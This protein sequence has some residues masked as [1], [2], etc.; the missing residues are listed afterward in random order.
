MSVGVFVLDMCAH[1]YLFSRYSVRVC[2]FVCLCTSN[3]SLSYIACVSMCFRNCTTEFL[4]WNLFFEII[5]HVPLHMY[6]GVQLINACY[7]NSLCVG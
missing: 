3:S 4:F 6:I 1:C 5:F 2:A 7:V